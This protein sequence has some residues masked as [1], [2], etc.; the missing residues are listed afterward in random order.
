MRE[1][2]DPS[3]DYLT[4]DGYEVAVCEQMTVQQ[5]VHAL[6]DKTMSGTI[7]IVDLLA[8]SLLSAS[9]RPCT[10]KL[11]RHG[12]IPARS[13]NLAFVVGASIFFFGT[14]CDCQ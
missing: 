2:A 6:P 1:Q 8:G 3:D 12:I 4:Y 10:K 14:R 7:P 11:L 13:R 9:G 5:I